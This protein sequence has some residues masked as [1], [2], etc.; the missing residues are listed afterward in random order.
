MKTCI[1]CRQL[2]PLTKFAQGLQARCKDCVVLETLAQTK[3]CVVCG[4]LKSLDEFSQD[5]RSTDK[6]RSRCK[7]CINLEALAKE[8]TYEQYAQKS[9]EGKRCI[10]CGKWKSIREFR[11]TRKICK[12]CHSEVVKKGKED[13]KAK[14]GHAYSTWARGKTLTQYLNDL[15]KQTRCRA[16]RNGQE[17]Q[18]TV[19][20]VMGLYQQQ[21]GKCALSGREMTRIVGEGRVLT[22]ISIDRIDSSKG[23]VSDNVQLVCCIVNWAKN[24]LNQAEFIAF[25]CDIVAL[26]RK[27]NS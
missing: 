5:L 19:E 10:R 20:W 18:L 27:E 8:R 9:K 16:A 7:A 22:N 11:S 4:Q 24:N 23:Y 14:T 13:F 25:C 3:T 21:E 26:H 2:K 1:A 12:V 17:C 6:K 15:L